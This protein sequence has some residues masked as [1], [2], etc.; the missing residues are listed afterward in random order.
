MKKEVQDFI[1]GKIFA[2]V[3]VSR[4]DKKFGSAIYTELKDRGYSVFGVNPNLTEFAGSPCYPTVGAINNKVDGVI[5]CVPPVKGEQIVKDTAAAGIKNIWLQQGADSPSLVKQAQ[6]LKLN[7]V[8]GKC[9][10][11]YM[12]PV[13]SFHSFHRF[14]AKLFGQM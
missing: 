13:K 1:Q 6:D 5:V 4:N 3:G 12:E 2:V 11:M 10:L 8:S 7:T 14:F 9:I